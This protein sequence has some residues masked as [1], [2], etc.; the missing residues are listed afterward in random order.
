MKKKKKEKGNH[1]SRCEPELRREFFFFSPVV[2]SERWRRLCEVGAR[3]ESIKIQS[4]WTE[5]NST[6]W[7][8][9]LL[10]QQPQTLGGE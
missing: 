1:H 5:L 10:I 7:L 8:I 2:Y 4:C 6:N 3:E 9:L